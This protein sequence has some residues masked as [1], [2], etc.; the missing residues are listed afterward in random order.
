MKIS[1]FYKKEYVNY[2]SYDNI[3]KIASYVDG[4]KN[5]ARKIL[6]TIIEKNIKNKIKVSQLGSKAAEFGEYLH[7]DIS[8]VIVTLGQDYAGT[9]NLPL[10]QKS[11]N[12]GTRF[13]PEASASRYIFTYGSDAFFELF[14]KE[15]NKIL[16]HQF[17]EG[18]RI[19]PMFYVP[20]LPML[21]INGSEGLSSGFAQKILPRDPK[22]IKQYLMSKLQGKNSRYKFE[23]YFVGF[24]G[25]VEQGENSAQWLIKGVIKRKGVN[26]VQILEVP[27]GYNLK[28]YIKVLDDL[29]DKKIIQSY[30]D[31]SENDVFNFEVTIP[32][33]TLK[34]WSDEEILQ[35]L[36][37]IKKVTE[38]YTVID[39]NNKIQV[40]N[41]PKEI[42]EK[43]IDIKLQYMLLRK[44]NSIKELTEQLKIDFSKYKFIELIVNDKLIINKRK[45]VD[46]VKDLDKIDDIQKVQDSYDFLLNLNI[47]YL[48]EERMK[49]LKE[50]IYINNKKINNL[51]K[52]TIETLWIEDL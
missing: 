33:K 5:A 37:L 35:N 26:K 9:N 19:E 38:N 48:T 32:S 10:L 3:R 42:M 6:Y 29:E 44:N 28:S 36:K 13:S 25:V 45:K 31:K 50:T 34:D 8:P 46:I 27:V 7:G 24:N 12:F 22:K 2:S 41:S 43:Y 14:K 18:E 23:P 39:E 20:T 21:L 15:D 30:R 11:G 47:G 17:F 51:K 52:K 40:L 16:K 4:Q 1:D 49:K